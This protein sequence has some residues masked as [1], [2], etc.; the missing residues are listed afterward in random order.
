MAL[1]PLETQEL[2]ADR[3]RASGI[4]Q[5]DRHGLEIAG[6]DKRRF[7]EGRIHAVDILEISQGEQRLGNRSTGSRGWPF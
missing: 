7:D 5:H 4:D 1:Q 3:V 6:R 2:A